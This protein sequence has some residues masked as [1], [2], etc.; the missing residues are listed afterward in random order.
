[1]T[2]NVQELKRI[3][4]D[5]ISGG[6]RED[7]SPDI[8]RKIVVFNAFALIGILNLILLG[9]LAYL[10][11]NVWLAGL[12]YCEA[13]ALAFLIIYLRS[14][15]DYKTAFYGS[16][17]VVGILYYYL[18]FTGGVNNTAH[19]WYF[20][21][22]LIASFILGSRP[23][24][25]ATLIMLV[26]AVA[27]FMWDNP[28]SPFTT[29]SR[30]FKLRFI[31]SFLVI[32][33]F[34]YFFERTREKATMRLESTVAT[35]KETEE[36]LRRA[37]E[38]LEHRV[39]E[40]T[41]QLYRANLQLAGEM[42]ERK[43]SEEALRE[44][45]G[46]LNAM[47]RSVG[48]SMI[49]I[50]RELNVIWYNEKAKETFAL[51][52]DGAKCHDMLCK[53]PW[54]CEPYPCYALQAFQDGGIHNSDATLKTREGQDAFFHCV[55]NAALRDERGNPTA[56]LTILRDITDRKAAENAVMESEKKYR[57]LFEDSV[58]AMSISRDGRMIDVNPAWLVL[59][60]YKDKGEVLGRDVM[61]FIQPED[62]HILVERRETWPHHDFRSYQIR[63]IRRDGDIV[64]IEICASKIALAGQGAILTTI[65][66]ITEKKRTEREKKS[67]EERLA[68]SE[69]MEA[70]GTLAG[71][72]AHDLNNILGGMVGYPDLLLMEVPEDSLLR[73]GILTIKQSGEKAAAIVQDLLTLARRGVPVM[74]PV[75]LNRII[76][77]YLRSPEYQKLRSF[78]PGVTV[79]NEL[80]GDLLPISG[81]S[82]HLSKVVM[83]L[84]S[85]AAEAMPC[86]GTIRIETTN[87][88]VDAAIRGY[89]HV[90]EGEY[91]V[92]K[93]IDTGI[94]IAQKDIKKI[95]EPF[96][97]KK[98][99]GRSGT[100]LGMAVVWGT[101]KDHKGYI[102]I[103]SVEGR[104]STFS[105][106]FPVNR[107][108]LK[109]EDKKISIEQFL[110]KGETIL[111][112]DDVAEQRE[113]A[114][115]MLRKLGYSTES[116]SSGE[117][118]VEYLK[119]K[120]AN[121]II[122]DMIMDPGIDG[123]ET[124]R[125]IAEHRPGQKA[126]IVSGFAETDR[127][128]EAQKLGAGQYLK[129]PYTL[130]KIAV[131]VRN[132]LDKA[133]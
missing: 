113:L 20:T 121:L 102:D 34:A 32:T 19:V 47:L 30:D 120:P 106:Y 41:A 15:K 110:S 116:L 74:E 123:L 100:G 87:Q 52:C 73:R 65:R 7:L 22:P 48:D 115:A 125:K 111:V 90:T 33:A 109:Q 126:I 17:I 85:N 77:D 128:K 5:L 59:H 38:E 10:Q 75:N 35:L 6:M 21:Y 64:D 124:Y 13:V 11:K 43:R 72:V 70:I 84:I 83:N 80:A 101:V 26:P 62:R 66:D 103:E 76:T 31:P 89:D 40:R 45:E 91:I 129:K 12:D 118:A 133:A 61:E 99:M 96:Y 24:L 2:V 50:D 78:H 67:L 60:G 86:G 98:I 131:A 58:E 57:T 97:T 4:F 55:A 95:F 71:G 16:V 127:V 112:V 27:F 28:T 132:E 9:T 117:E 79:G 42:E 49:M 56:V 23:G 37:G 18:L 29:Y 130:E 81:S 51:G 92:L 63:D 104:G 114:S 53:R 1:M 122:L 25:A 39:E 54:P 14:T 68:R 82:V 119:Q 105:L 94:G 8:S 46:K 93:V 88:Y 107:A 36:K 69:K 44:S 108:V 3:S